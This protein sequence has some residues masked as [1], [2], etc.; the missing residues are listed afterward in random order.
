M[1]TF[2]LII[3]I[4]I[5]VLGFIILIWIY[6]FAEDALANA[7]FSLAAES[8]SEG[9]IADLDRFYTE[10][11]RLH[12]HAERLKKQLLLEYGDAPPEH[13]CGLIED[14]DE[15]VAVHRMRDSR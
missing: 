7:R 5:G 13:I 15:M 6:N 8:A 11:L 10:R 1:D 12:K 2:S 14:I 4:V 9:V 3:G